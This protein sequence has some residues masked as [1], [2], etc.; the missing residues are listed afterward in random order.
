M[1]KRNTSMSIVLLAAVVAAVVGCG[2]GRPPRV[3]VAGRVTV[4]GQPLTSGQVVFWPDNGVPARGQIGADGVFRLSTFG[5]GDGAVLGRHVVTIEATRVENPGPKLASLQE[6]IDYYRDPA[7]AAKDAEKP[8]VHW[9]APERY[10][11]RETSGLTAEVQAGRP[12][13][14][15]F[16]LP[17]S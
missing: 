11:Q 2:D 9:L 8:V 13:T 15:D 10:A 6:E 14:I 17:G 12:N 16:D 5:D 3:P 7:N 1:D 4:G